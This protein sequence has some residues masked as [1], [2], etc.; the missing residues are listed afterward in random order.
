MLAYETIY[1]KAFRTGIYGEFKIFYKAYAEN[2]N[3]SWKNNKIVFA[4]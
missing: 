2:R 3:K 4:E 1:G